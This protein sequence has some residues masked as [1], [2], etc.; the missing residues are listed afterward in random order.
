MTDS[1]I[2]G[3]VDDDLLWMA[4]LV[5]NTFL[6]SR[7]LH[8]SGSEYINACATVESNANKSYSTLVEIIVALKRLSSTEYEWAYELK[9][10]FSLSNLAPEI[11]A[12]YKSHLSNYEEYLEKS[13]SPNPL[14]LPDATT[15]TPSLVTSFQV[16]LSESPPVVD[17]PRF[18]SPIVDVIVS[19]VPDSPI[20]PPLL[21]SKV[22]GISSDSDTVS[23]ELPKSLLKALSPHA[24]PF[25]PSC[26][27]LHTG[28]VLIETRSP[29]TSPTFKAG[30]NLSPS[31][32]EAIKDGHRREACK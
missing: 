32:K 12:I 31:H 14:P 27:Q 4:I 3:L 23:S 1:S 16:I 6:L 18:L 7:Q 28:E 29:S 30:C 24:L 10:L 17:I 13:L 8:M 22:P 20:I 9:Y 11:E 2:P 21:I 19:S 5:A 25:V 15:V 26:L